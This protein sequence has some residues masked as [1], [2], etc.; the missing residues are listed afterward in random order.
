[1]ATAADNPWGLKDP[2]LWEPGPLKEQR[3]VP[4]TA[5]GPATVPPVQRDNAP[6]WQ[7]PPVA[8]PAATQADVDLTEP[9][10]APA[11]S[12]AR[13]PF[14]ATDAQP[15][16]TGRAG[17]TPVWVRATDN[18]A[19]PQKSPAPA[20]AANPGAEAKPASNTPVA[21]GRVGVTI[22]E[23]G[24]AEQAGVH[25]LVVAVSPRDAAARGTVVV[26]VDYASIQGAFGG[27]WAT[28][29]RLVALPS[30]ALTTPEKPE[31]RTQT[32]VASR[33]DLAAKQVY[34]DVDL[35]ASGP[36]TATG[37]QS[38]AA[39][40][41][42]VL[43]ATAAPSGPNGDYTAT[44]L[45]P[46]GS[47][48]AGGNSGTFSWNYPITVPPALGGTA[49]NIAL[50]Y[51]S[52]TVDG[53]TS[54]RNGQASWIGE[55]WDYQ[56]GYIERFHQSCKV[57]GKDD[58]GEVCWSGKQTV[59]M[60]LNGSNSALVR[61]DATGTWR[62]QDGAPTKVE[63]STLPAG[64]ENGDND[65]EYWK[66]TTGD[67]T[68]Y[69]F[70]AQLR[71]GAATGEASNSVWT[72][73]VFANDSGEPCYNTDFAAAW[74]QQAWRWNLDYVIDARGNLVSY[75]YAKETN[76][77][78]RNP[79]QAHPDGTLTEYTRGGQLARVDY[80][81]KADSTAGPTARVIFTPEERCAPGKACAP[82]GINKDN[83]ADWPDVPFDQSCAMSA[84]VA[85]CKNYSPTFWSTR[86]LKSITTQVLTGGNPVKVDEWALAYDVPNPS[87]GS[88][89]VLWL[90]SITR[91]AFAGD[92]NENNKITMPSTDFNGQFKP[93]RV[94]Y[95][96][97]TNLTP[98]NRRRLTDITTGT[99]GR[100][101]VTYDTACTAGQF[102][103][104]SSNTTRCYPVYWNPSPGTPMDPTLDWFHKY[105]VTGVSETDTTTPG[106]RIR[107]TRYEYVG[108]AA[109]HRD[110]SELTDDDFRTWNDFRGY[111]EV[112]TRTGNTISYPGDATLKSS[113][114]YLRGM[115]SPIPGF[116]GTADVNPLAGFVRETVTYNGDTTEVVARTVNDPK[117]FPPSAT[118]SRGSALPAQTAQMVR[119]E[120]TT[121]KSLLSNGQWRSSSKTTTEFDPEFGV[122][123]SVLDS[124]E[125]L[126][127]YCTTTK[128]AHN[129]ATDAYLIALPYETYTVTGNCGVQPGSTT[130]VTHT[131]TL[132][133]GKPLG[134]LGQIGAPTT[135]QVVVA[136]NGGIPSRILGTVA[137]YD[138]YGRLTRVTDPANNATTTTYSPATGGLP[139]R[140]TT[141]G[142]MGADWTTTV[143]YSTAR[144]LAV[145]TT[146]LNGR[147]TE[148]AYDPAG[149]TTAVWKP[150]R[151]RGAGKAA[152]ILF[153]YAPSKTAPSVVTTKTL[154]DEG[155]YAISR[156]I[157]D[158]F[159][160]Q[161]QTQ[162]DTADNSPGRLVTDTFYD[163]LGR[164]LKANKTYWDKT[165]GPNGVLWQ[166]NDNM[167]PGQTAVFYDG[168][169][170]KTKETFS[171][172]AVDQTSTP[173][174][175]A[176]V[177]QWSTLTTYAGSER[178]SVVPPDGGT[179]T[180]VISDAR[181]KTAELRQ[182]RDRTK[183]GQDDPLLFDKTVYTY[184]GREQLASVTGPTHPTDRPTGDTWTWRYDL[185]G[186]Q[187]HTEDP[188]KG[189]VD[190]VYDDLGRVA[191][192]TDARG[193]TLAYAYDKISRKTG[194]Y[195][196]SVADANILASW[197]YDRLAKG[198]ADGSTR[199]VGGKN[200]AAYSSALT[201]L[202]TAYRPTGSSV[203]I[204]ATEGKLAG[205]YT[206]GQTYTNNIGLPYTTSLPAA[207]DLPAE[208][209]YT[210]YGDRD[211]PVTLTNGSVDYVN[212][213]LYDPFGRVK[214]VTLGDVPKQ[215][216]HTPIFDD[217]TGRLMTTA[218]DRQTGPNGEPIGASVDL[219]NYTYKANGDITSITTRRDDGAVDRQCFTYDYLQRMTQAWTDEG[220]LQTQPAPSVPGIGGCKNQ[221]PSTAT[222]GGPSPYWQTYLFDPSGNRT[223]LVEH[224]PSGNTAKDVTT[225]YTSPAGGQPQPHSVTNTTTRVGTSTVTQS[226]DYDAAGNTSNR[227][228]SST[229]GNVGAIPTLPSTRT[230]E[231]ED[232][233]TANLVATSNKSLDR[234]VNCCGVTWSGG[235]HLLTGGSSPADGDWVT[236][237][238]NVPV[239]GPYTLQTQQTVAGDFARIQAKV[240]ADANG[241]GGTDIGPVF[242]AY[243][244]TVGITPVT[245][246][247]VNLPAGK[248]KVTFKVTGKD[249]AATGYRMGIDTLTLR[250]GVGAE[251]ENLTRT[252]SKNVWSQ[253]NCCGASWSSR[254]QSVLSGA[255]VGDWVTY[256]FT[257]PRDGMYQVAT[258]QTKAAD[259]G[260]IQAQI[261]GKDIGQTWDSNAS[262]VQV[263]D[264][265]WSTVSLTAGTHTFTQ[266]LTGT[267]GTGWLIGTD[268][269]FL[270]PVWTAEGE[271]LKVTANTGGIGAATCCG[272]TWSG[273]K[274]LHFAGTKDGDTFTVDVNVPAAGEYQI[275]TKQTRAAQY[276]QT[277]LTVD[278]ASTGG[279]PFDAYKA[280]GVDT[281]TANYGKVRLTPG[282]HKLTFTVRPSPEALRTNV[283]PQFWI[284]LDTLTLT[285]TAGPDGTSAPG[286]NQELT[287]DAEGRLT[288]V[289]T[290]DTGLTKTSNYLYDADGNRLLRIDPDKV[291]LYLGTTELTL[292]G[293][294]GNTTGTFTG[295]RYYSAPGGAPTIV[296]T[297]NKLHYQATDRHGTS[298]VSLDAATLA[299]TR[300][301]TKPYGDPRGPQPQATAWPDDKGFL[302]K[303]QDSTGLTHVGA[304]E[305]DPG[306]GRFISVDPIM[307]LADPQQMHGYSY[308]NGNPVTKSDPTGMAPDDCDANGYTCGGDAQAGCGQLCNGLGSLPPTTPAGSGNG[309]NGSGGGSSGSPG[310][311]PV[312]PH[313]DPFLL[314][315]LPAG[316]NHIDPTKALTVT[317]PLNGM[318]IWDINGVPHVVHPQGGGDTPSARQ[319]LH[320]LNRDLAAGGVLYDP[321]LGSGAIYYAQADWYDNKPGQGQIVGKGKI[322]GV[323]GPSLTGTTADFI[324][325]DYQNGKIVSVDSYDTMTTSQPQKSG[326]LIAGELRRKMDGSK[327]QANNTIFVAANDVQASEVHA[328]MKGDSRVRV[329][330]LNLSSDT[331]SVSRAPRIG[332]KSLT[333]AGNIAMIAWL[334]VYIRN[335]GLGRGAYKFTMDVVDPFHLTGDRDDSFDILFNGK[336]N[337]P[338]S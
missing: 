25:G 244:A 46:T 130:T 248:S 20:G 259:Y 239:A 158:A 203:T 163:S 199:Y 210:G 171:S 216:V 305:Y 65:R 190:T 335:D 41:M 292:T 274:F 286:G 128:Y 115:D 261:D 12:A 209:L 55:G 132:Y 264:V 320:I 184:D 255:G 206:T 233:N 189:P 235:K 29:V 295:T 198:Q 282:T 212:R 38:A 112:I 205:T 173:T 192:T 271:N 134:E 84:P 266:K 277:H 67:G 50:A 31:C 42:T 5:A 142:P 21:T 28:R 135:A 208:T 333:V 300:R 281:A 2:T 117:V 109:W 297:G 211:L 273:G 90:A 310:M 144:N 3:S 324:R 332:G 15:K 164:V 98:L 327:Q 60:S 48:S 100:I 105:A 308:A 186:R 87:D 306:L 124:A 217:A 70:G 159:L 114:I 13:S 91:T 249:A 116:S 176:R 285:P 316:F 181:G 224:D 258:R 322:Q 81:Y 253:P 268:A 228:A 95:Q 136:Y 231:A 215:V 180:T 251:A 257:V 9:P 110:D 129:R 62:T 321:S 89:P 301:D 66:V 243:R 1:M 326:T 309:G 122:A 334:P 329:I 236:F 179:A 214:R 170:R 139:T 174:G 78:A 10:A 127:D 138:I 40:G 119:T 106:S 27:D 256:T 151:D 290:V 7:A 254:A 104:P 279:T 165:T 222:V 245:W 61:D 146:D 177:Q 69:Y 45:S 111:A 298:G 204:P 52:A 22:A 252:G 328:A 88:G 283:T 323:N 191:S 280:T 155:S 143:D 183:V 99:G 162:T 83:Q 260:I 221:T 232:T 82:G 18:P 200:G 240:G 194:L 303:P 336:V 193:Q 152:D 118:H 220:D 150:G 153:E 223:Q 168:L 284:G 226:Y 73:P 307:D 85:D 57:D 11:A 267:N 141:T 265:V 225:D 107:T 187:V 289:K 24:K 32:P 160:Q 234:Q 54:A 293:A 6:P 26:G 207:G 30:C 262:A 74:C 182:Y 44:P 291:T 318:T 330:T 103:T 75:V 68:R 229:P 272:T 317:H 140:V 312:L 218:L 276:G 154:R 14:A 238:V 80:G 102:P 269:L 96:T 36:S 294:R 43:A 34:A 47:W 299:L 196:G 39:D 8:W 201:G 133:D 56:P 167:V 33:N 275:T 58:T 166:A 93:N 296:R 338:V 123:Q 63:P 314:F 172:Y 247:S 53:Q 178:T 101:T 202:D 94:Q 337:M 219:T 185:L 76:A 169:G 16:P 59:T 188:D 71:P 304:R 156:Q 64:V 250:A 120:K 175:G 137:E 241:N 288:A 37:T 17:A 230:W 49:P 131:R 331:K 148:V 227:P 145:K 197:S 125:G 77:Y 287:W 92:G 126:P 97:G 195:N 263:Q 149:R 86:R 108:G 313:G 302:G 213:A 4:G 113:T 147:V 121:S 79:D 72:R 278:G 311:G 319:L 23:R 35:A 246:G 157:Y 51:S 315:S 325:V 237:E 242:N 270:N 161:R 19:P